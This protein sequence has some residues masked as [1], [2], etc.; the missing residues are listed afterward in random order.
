LETTGGFKPGDCI[1]C[2]AHTGIGHQFANPFD[3]NLVY[4]CINM[5]DPNDACT[6]PDN[7]KIMIDSLDKLGVLGERD[8]MAGEPDLPAIFGLYSGR[9]K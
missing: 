6:Y 1:F 3:E 2:P 4:L 7:G 5:N 8:Y 9:A